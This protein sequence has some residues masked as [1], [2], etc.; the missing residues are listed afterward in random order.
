MRPRRLSRHYPAR[1]IGPI[2]AALLG[3]A[4]E[5]FVMSG[6]NVGHGS[7][8]TVDH[9]GPWTLQGVAQGAETLAS[10][11]GPGR[12]YFR[13]DAATEF[14]SETAWPS[15]ANDSNL[16]ALNDTT[17]HEGKLGAD[18]TIDGQLVPSGTYV[19]QF[20]EFPDLYD[21]YA[22]GTSLPILFR[23]CKFRFS[24]GVS[25]A[26]LFNDNTATSSQHILMHYCDIGL[27]GPNIGLSTNSGLMHIKH[28]GGTNHRYLR[29]YF[30]YSATFLQ[31]NVQGCVVQ[32]NLM[33]NP[34]FFYGELGPNGNGDSA[35]YHLNGCSSEGGITSVQYVRNKIDMTSP[36]PS[37]GSAGG[38]AAGQPGY[39]TQSGQ[40]GYVGGTNP[41]RVTGQT[42]CI[43]MFAIT[44]ANVGTSPGSILVQD[45]WFAGSGYCLYAGNADASAQNIHVIGNRVSTKYWT[46]GGQFGGITDVPSWNSNGNYQADNLY[47]DDYGTGGDGAT[48]TADRRYPAGNGPRVGTSWV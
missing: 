11:T 27:T 23:G 28:L 16:A 35:T 17:L 21:F 15:N 20:R 46:N 19:C 48:A 14:T 13:F 5:P 36:D 33:E 47:I 30:S 32:E 10:V 40:T 42:D 41:G 4:G 3:G 26:G 43:A 1:R 37:T 2:S 9:V 38:N 39:G 31:P 18:M 34:I 29:N 25:G 45:N 8:L 12:G 22:Q 44:S 6:G 24:S 7:Q